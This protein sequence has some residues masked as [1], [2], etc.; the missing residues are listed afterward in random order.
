MRYT[1][2]NKLF[3]FACFS[4]PPVLGSAV[5]FLWHG[6]ALWCL[7]E[8][9]SGR[10][11]LS[12][13]RHMRIFT[14]LLY[15]YV[16]ANILSFLLNAPR[17]TDVPLLLPLATFLLFPFS[18]SIWS[19]SE[20]DPVARAAALASMT[21]SYGAL[22]FALVQYFILGMARVEGG[23]GNALVFASAASMAGTISLAGAF[24][25]TTRWQLPLVGGYFA[26][27]FAVLLSGSR[28]VWMVMALASLAILFACRREI[29]T[30]IA[31][32]LVKVL[33][34]ASVVAALSSGVLASRVESLAEDWNKLAQAENYNSSLG[35]RWALWQ[36]G[37]EQALDRPLLG[38]G[39]QNT[40]KIIERLAD[41]FGL[42]AR[43]THFHNGF[44]TI[45]VESG[46]VG[47][48]AMIGVFLLAGWLALRTLSETEETTARLGGAILIVFFLNYLIGGSFNIVVGHDILDT[49]FMILLITGS[50]L[51]CGTAVPEATARLH[52]AEAASPEKECGPEGPHL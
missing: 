17:W 14:V 43:F 40:R 13:D 18:Y 6:G 50:L 22:A 39:L 37:V 32:H 9:A 16:A 23:A 34:V 49:L 1:T 11:A 2:V 19:I 20:K 30:F 47:A 27:A 51:A 25:L 29:R 45:F 15:T 5:A 28:S 31:G 42:S 10:R 52:E 48:G 36:G 4:T 8:V 3:T 35:T 7:F 21:A 44:L 24:M 33:L 41:E 12:A 26:A 46:L 38:N